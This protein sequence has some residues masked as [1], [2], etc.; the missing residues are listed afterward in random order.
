QEERSRWDLRIRDLFHSRAIE[1]RRHNLGG[2]APPPPDQAALQ[3]VQNATERQIAQPGRGETRRCSGPLGLV[4]GALN[5]ADK[6]PATLT[7]Y[8]RIFPSE[9]GSHGKQKTTPAN[10]SVR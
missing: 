9:S 4:F 8:F 1:L 6:D 5:G 3:A 7:S 10:P 2:T